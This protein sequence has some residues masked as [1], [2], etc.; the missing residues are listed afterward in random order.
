LLEFFISFEI[1]MSVT[2][3]S[4]CLSKVFILTIKSVSKERELD[5]A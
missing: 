2:T 4:I 3:V 1:N 5:Y